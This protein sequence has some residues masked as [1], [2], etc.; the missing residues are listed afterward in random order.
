MVPLVL[1]PV[2]T[3]A[4]RS[5]GQSFGEKYMRL[6]VVHQP[7]SAISEQISGELKGELAG[8]SATA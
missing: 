1:V 3:A 7:P 4:T 5:A 8:K 6:F 2:T